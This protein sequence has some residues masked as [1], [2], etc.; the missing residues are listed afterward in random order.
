MTV[1][2]VLNIRSKQIS[3]NTDVVAAV[4]GGEGESKDRNHN[5]SENLSS[6]NFKQF[7][8]SSTKAGVRKREFDLKRIKPDKKKQNSDLDLDFDLSD[9]L[10][11]IVS[12]LHLIRDKAQKDG[13]GADENNGTDNDFVIAEGGGELKGST[14]EDVRKRLGAVQLEAAQL[15]QRKKKDEYLQ[16]T[17]KELHSRFMA[18]RRFDSFPS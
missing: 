14:A 13:S 1:E 5:N 2:E 10:K 3:D 16:T 7:A 8:M 18:S 9:N 6:H 4:E 11:G 15:D 17:R 12:A